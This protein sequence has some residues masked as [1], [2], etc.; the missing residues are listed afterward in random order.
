MNFRGIVSCLTLEERN[1]RFVWSQFF[2][3][4]MLVVGDDD[5]GFPCDRKKK[6]FEP[7]SMA[8][9]NFSFKRFM[10]P[11]LFSVMPLCR[12]TLLFILWWY[13]VIIILSLSKNKGGRKKFSGISTAAGQLSWGGTGRP[14][15]R[16]TGCKMLGFKPRPPFLEEF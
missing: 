8:V 13:K 10:A 12:W 1:E 9:G 15:S 5:S 16:E 4:V 3:K 11:E 7:V 14:F 2:C 6:C